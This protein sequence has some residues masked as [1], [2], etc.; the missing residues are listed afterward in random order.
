MGRSA[1]SGDIHAEN[2]RPDGAG[3]RR[4][5]WRWPCSTREQ[6]GVPCSRRRRTRAPAASS[7]PAYRSNPVR[8]AALAV[9]RTGARRTIAGGRR[10]HEPAAG[11]LLR[12]DRRRPVE[13]HRRR[14]DVARGL[15]SLL[16]D[17]LGRRHRGRPSRTPTSSTSAWARRSCAATS[18][19]ATASTS[20]STAARPSRTSDS[21]RRMAIA[22]IRVHPSNPDIVYVAALGNPYGPNPER[23]VFKST[24][25][26]KTWTRVALPRREDRRRGPV[27]GSEEP[28]RALRRSLGGLPHAAFALERRTRQRAVQDDRRGRALDG[29]DEERRASQ[30]DLGESRRLGLRRRSEPRLRDRR[31]RRGRGLPVR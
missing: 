23:G 12:R 18:S 31:G 5:A 14:R 27:D 11:V 4:S 6:T 21:R 13:D 10:Q 3:A 29:A 25:G 9:R 2:L 17:L 7:V 1:T 15:R 20:P 28:G 19:R 16:Q 26:G 30:T 22:R 24:D 8:R